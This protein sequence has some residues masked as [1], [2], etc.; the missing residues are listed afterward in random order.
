MRFK[1]TVSLIGQDGNVFNLM[2]IVVK[3]LRENG[4]R[5]EAKQFTEEAMNAS[6][7]EEVT[8]EIIPKYVEVT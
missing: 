2:G 6:S 1:P 4:Q 7:Y 5:D 8:Q 3:A